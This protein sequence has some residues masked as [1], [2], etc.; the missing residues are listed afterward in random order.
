MLIIRKKHLTLSLF[1]LFFVFS[2]CLIG[3]NEINRNYQI[4]QVSSLPVDKKVVIID[5]GH[6]SEKMVE[7]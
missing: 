5:A 1:F 3:K 6:R 4:T 7:L 2:I